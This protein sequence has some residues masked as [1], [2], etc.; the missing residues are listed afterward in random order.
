[1][2]NSVQFEFT[3]PLGIALIVAVLALLILRET[4]PNPPQRSL[5]R[6]RIA[7][8][9]LL[10]P[11]V[12]LLV[13][14]LSTQLVAIAKPIFAAEIAAT[15][16]ERATATSE[17]VN[18]P[19][20][21]TPAQAVTVP[22]EPTPTPQDLPTPTPSTPAPSAATASA[23]DVS[24]QQVATAVNRLQSGQF[25]IQITYTDTTSSIASIS[26]DLGDGQRLASLYSLTTYQG[27]T[28][29]RTTERI[30]I[31][32]RTWTR[33]EGGAW[34]VGVTSQPVR[35]EIAALLT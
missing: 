28:G 18:T 31:G 24:P 16:A 35:E 9:V 14:S 12:V 33:A 4:L 29:K 2:P 32:E 25:S 21:T 10:V 5:R 34:T 3:G 6:W 15:T 19:P 23:Q 8:T 22:P 30:V 27:M 17:P 13:A 7:L 11:L 20:V 1:M 26:F